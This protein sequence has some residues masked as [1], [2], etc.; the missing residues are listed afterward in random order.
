[1]E[2]PIIQVNQIHNGR[3]NCR[4]R[5]G[6]TKRGLKDQCSGVADE[7]K[8]SRWRGAWSI[9]IRFEARTPR[10]AMWWLNQ[11][12]RFTPIADQLLGCNMLALNGG[13]PE[14]AG[15]LRELS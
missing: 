3:T 10:H 11:L 15:T 2:I 5:L 13:R 9:E 7:S 12:F 4:S 6:A 14:T 1:M 8:G